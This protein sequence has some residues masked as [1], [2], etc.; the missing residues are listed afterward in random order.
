MREAIILSLAKV[1]DRHTIRLLQ[2]LPSDNSRLEACRK[3]VISYLRARTIIQLPVG[4]P[5]TELFELAKETF[6]MDNYGKARF[7]LENILAMTEQSHSS[8]FD[9]LTLLARSCAEMGDSSEAINLI[10]PVLA[11]LPTKSRRQVSKDVASWLWEQLVFE[12]YDSAND[13]D[14]LLALDIHLDH[15]LTSNDPDEVLGNLRR[16]TRWLEIVGE[17]EI[18]QWIRSMVRTEAPGTWYID[19][20]N[21]SQY[22]RE[23][24]L[25]ENLKSQL[26]AVN[27]RIRA[28]IP[29]KLSQVLQSP[30]VLRGSDYLL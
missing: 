1:G 10:K 4:I 25:S 21:R 16:L 7:L 6:D 24:E 20:L 9:A 12:A 29:D 28:G 18:A 30:N 3:N 27:D 8:Y 5:S 23:V 14:Y 13:E 17:G 22:V 26:V 15:A 11:E 2:N 19:S